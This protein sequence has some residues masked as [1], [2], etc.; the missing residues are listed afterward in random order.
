M[1]QVQSYTKT[2]PHLK[3]ERKV[4]GRFRRGKRALIV[5][6]NLRLG[7][8]GGL[9]RGRC[10]RSLDRSGCRGISRSGS[11]CRSTVAGTGITSGHRCRC[12]GRRIAA[13][14]SGTRLLITFRALSKKLDSISYNFSGIAFGACLVCPLTGAEFTLNVYLA[15]FMDV[16]F[17]KIGIAA[18][19]NNAMPFCILTE[20]SVT[21][22]EAFCGG[23]AERCNFGICC[24]ILGIGFKVTYLRVI[25]NVTDKHY[26][27]QCHNNSCLVFAIY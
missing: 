15:A 13:L 19:Y 20:F 2:R 6:R 18:P 9:H 1:F 4:I 10:Y 16:F 7:C 5:R 22:T 8:G 14:V 21:V 3:L 23:K 26:F 24:G 12:R 11:C 25:S 17:H 27:V